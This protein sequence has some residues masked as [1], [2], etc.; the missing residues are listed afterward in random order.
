MLKKHKINSQVKDSYT[1]KQKLDNI[2]DEITDDILI[3]INDEIN[4][5]EIDNDKEKELIQKNKDKNETVK[6][7]IKDS[8]DDNKKDHIDTIELKKISTKKDKIPKLFCTHCGYTFPK[9][10]IPVDYIITCE[11]C[12]RP[13]ELPDHYY[14]F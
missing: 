12:N 7:G 6:D 3:D 4:E 8:N 11:K 14:T 1:K 10:K 5:I 9:P 2:F 13:L